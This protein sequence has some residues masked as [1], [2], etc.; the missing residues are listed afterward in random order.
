MD[1]IKLV[2]NV[3]EAFGAVLLIPLALLFHILT[4]LLM[5]LIAIETEVFGPTLEMLIFRHFGSTHLA[6]FQIF[7]I[8]LTFLKMLFL[9]TQII[10]SH[11]LIAFM[12][13]GFT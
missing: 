5:I 9:F 10:H 3:L 8:L 2:L 6:D 11:T 4:Y 7:S 13:P 1:I 12:S